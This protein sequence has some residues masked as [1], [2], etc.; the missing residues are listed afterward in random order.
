MKE[1]V[2]RKFCYCSTRR[3]TCAHHGIWARPTCDNKP[4]NLIGT[5]I[6]ETNIDKGNC[7]EQKNVPTVT[8]AWLPLIPR[9]FT[10]RMFFVMSFSANNFVSF[11][12]S[13][14]M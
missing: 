1:S 3:Q 11:Q 2:G 8:E 13:I 4:E 6:G 12:V 9:I 10:Q 5:R 14:I 7:S